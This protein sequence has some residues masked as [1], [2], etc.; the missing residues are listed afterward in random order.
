MAGVAPSN[1]GA[2]SDY[3]SDFGSDDELILNSL[4]EQTPDKSTTFPALAL[5]DIEDNDGPRG[6]KFPRV[7]GRE[8]RETAKALRVGE[9]GPRSRIPIEVEGYRSVSAPGEYRNEFRD[10]AD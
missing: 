1:D 8:K 5:G 9:A 3:G 10:N 7:L 2:G 6:A 4:L